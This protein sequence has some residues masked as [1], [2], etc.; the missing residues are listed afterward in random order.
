MP[1]FYSYDKKRNVVRSYAMSDCGSKEFVENMHHI[2]Q[3]DDI[4]DGFVELI[5]MERMSAL[6]VPA[7]E[8]DNLQDALTKCEEKG[9]KRFVFFHPNPGQKDLKLAKKIKGMM[10]KSKVIF[11]RNHDTLHELTA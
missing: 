3:S 10:S 6:D 11:T 8:L 4:N 2:A 5:D 7:E 9:C 1:V